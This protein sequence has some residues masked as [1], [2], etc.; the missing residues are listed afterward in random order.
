[1]VKAYL[2]KLGILFATFIYLSSFSGCEKDELTYPVKVNFSININQATSSQT[3]LTLSKSVVCVGNISFIGIRQQGGDVHFD[4]KPG[5]N[6]GSH[7]INVG[8][9]A[10]YITY[11]DIP[12]GIYNYMGWDM[13]FSEIDEDIFDDENID[14]DDFG[15]II[16][17]TYTKTSGAQIPIYF[18]INP[19]EIINCETTNPDN[20]TPIS[21]VKDNTYNMLVEINP[22]EAI[23]GISR[24]YF[25]QAIVEIGEDEDSVDHILVSAESNNSLYQLFLF[26]MEKTLKATML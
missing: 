24:E 9:P 18:A 16:I 4:T 14:S 17:G 26:R 3:Y 10:Q 20:S 5:V 22:S 19:S 13:S 25:E 6:Q 7:I 1:M 11:F 15:M 2:K 21:I 23:E 8:Q 12:Q